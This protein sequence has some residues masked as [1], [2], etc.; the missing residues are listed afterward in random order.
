[1]LRS[2]RAVASAPWRP[3]LGL[4]YVSHFHDEALS[5]LSADDLPEIVAE[6]ETSRAW[7]ATNDAFIT[8]RIA[9]SGRGSA[10][11]MATPATA[12]HSRCGNK[13]AMARMTYPLDRRP[14]SLPHRSSAVP[15][16]ADNPAEEPR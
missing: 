1:M 4:Q 2:N 15:R 7:T 13:V 3:H 6:L 5:A 10:G 16:L 8:E 11:P 9:P 12:E 14:T